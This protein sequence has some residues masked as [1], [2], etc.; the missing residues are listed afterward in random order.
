MP[1]KIYK[2]HGTA[3]DS[4]GQKHIVTMIGRFETLKEERVVEDDVDVLLTPTKSTKGTIYYPV[5]RPIR[6]FSSGKR[7]VG[8]VGLDLISL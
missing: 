4:Q 8:V 6:T 3:T 5:K 1:K 2:M 7:C